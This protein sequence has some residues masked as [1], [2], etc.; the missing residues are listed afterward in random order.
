MRVFARFF[1]EKMPDDKHALMVRGPTVD[2]VQTTILVAEWSVAWAVDDT[3]R[4]LDNIL[5]NRSE[6]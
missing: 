5:P 3:L 6:Q 2:G 4:E 1:R